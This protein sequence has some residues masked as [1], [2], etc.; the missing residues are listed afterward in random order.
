MSFKKT[1]ILIAATAT[2]LL[3]YA[4]ILA[5]GKKDFEAKPSPLYPAKTYSDSSLV[6]TGAEEMNSTGLYSSLKLDSLGLNEPAFQQAL[7]G[8]RKL[9]SQGLLDRETIMTIADFSQPSTRKRLYV[10]DLES[11]KVLYHT[12][13]AHGRNS[14]KE[15]AIQYSNRPSS[16]QSSPGFYRTE[17][18]YYGSNGYSLRLKG[19]E[20]G[21][22]DNADRRA[23]VMHGAEYVSES[24]IRNQGYLGRS[25]GC[26]AIPVKLTRPIINTIKDGSCLFIYTPVTQYAQRSNL[27]R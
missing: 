19:L 22:N 15:H 10:I 17:G 12:Y 9:K 8:W 21:I 13:V 25:Q 18:T 1:G 2:I 11:K 23:I 14:G 16:Y 27:V 26:P 6:N 7:K 24:L 20:K 3:S 5:A 4:G